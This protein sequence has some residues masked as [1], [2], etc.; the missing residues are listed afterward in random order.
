V[1]KRYNASNDQRSLLVVA[2][3]QFV[4]KVGEP[5]NWKTIIDGGRT[6]LHTFLTL[7]RLRTTNKRAW[8][9]SEYQNVSAAIWVRA[10]PA[11]TVFAAVI[12]SA[13][14]HFLVS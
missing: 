4:C 1:S 11:R 10:L 13:A 12:C 2:S 8:A 9:S 7:L 14:L 6:D 5:A 3:Y